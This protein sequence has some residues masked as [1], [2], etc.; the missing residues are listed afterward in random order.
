MIPIDNFSLSWF[1]WP[2]IVEMPIRVA[3]CVHE[4]VWTKR[5]IY[6]DIVYIWKQTTLDYN[7][8]ATLMKLLHTIHVKFNLGRFQHGLRITM[9]FCVLGVCHLQLRCLAHS[10]RSQPRDRKTKQNKGKEKL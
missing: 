9:D 4:C 7:I 5:N 10:D 3:G 1:F 2:L 6:V 8:G